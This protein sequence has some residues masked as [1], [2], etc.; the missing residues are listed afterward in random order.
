MAFE[1]IITNAGR[2][3]LVNA[4][5]TGTDAVTVTQ[6]GISATAVAATPALTVLNGEIKRLAT[7]AGGAIAA[8]KITLQVLD[9]STDAY[10]LRSFALYLNDGTLFA[11]YGQADAI[12]IKTSNTLAQLEADVMLA[13][14]DAAM[15]EFGDPV[16]SNPPATETM[17]GIAK[18]A[19]QALTNV[20]LDDECFVTALK[21]MG[22]IN[23]LFPSGSNLNGNW[24]KMPDGNGGFFIHQWGTNFTGLGA[25]A[26][27]AG[28]SGDYQFPIPFTDIHSIQMKLTAQTLNV[29]GADSDLIAAE[30]LSLNTYRLGSEDIVRSVWWE[31]WGR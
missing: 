21:A 31:A 6:I 2:A 29:T 9:D 15:I 5:S 18:I 8:D 20:G 13:D 17:R 16:F 28:W 24:R 26:G 11:L 23:H 3:A 25:G 1:L 19:T 4:A 27:N 12:L 22:L 30:V 10:T 7:V 14:I